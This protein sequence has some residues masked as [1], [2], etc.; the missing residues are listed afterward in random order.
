MNAPQKHPSVLP[1]M[2]AVAQILSRFDR[3]QLEAFITVAIDLADAL[4]GDADIE[5]ATDLEDDFALSPLASGFGEGDG[6]GCTVSDPDSA[7]DDSGCDDINDDREHEE[8]LTMS[9]GI[10]QS[11]HL[12]VRYGLEVVVDFECGEAIKRTAPG[13]DF[14]QP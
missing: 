1:S 12:P 10:D 13:L 9:Y 2:P 8:L 7:V 4:D 5:N 6:P 3:K 11:N 14:S